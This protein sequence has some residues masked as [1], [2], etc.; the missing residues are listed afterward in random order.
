[1]AHK[2]DYSVIVYFPNA[3]FKKWKFVNSLKGF[4][5]FLDDK[6][7]EWLYMNV[8]DRRQAQYLKRFY[9]GN[10]VPVFLM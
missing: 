2:N 1:M 9:K 6:H 7:S 5:K 8:Y 4:A 10:E 3:V